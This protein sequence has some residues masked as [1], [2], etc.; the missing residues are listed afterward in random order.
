AAGV[1]LVAHCQRVVATGRR[2][3]AAGRGIGPRRQRLDHRA[4]L[5][6]PEHAIAAVLHS[7][8]V[9]GDVVHRI[10]Q[11]GDVALDIDDVAPDVGDIALDGGDP[12]FQVGN[13]SAVV[14]IDAVEACSQLA[15][16]D[17]IGAGDARRNAGDGAPAH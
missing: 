12:V 7:G 5:T 13:G 16:V 14:G 8:D 17:R 6:D 1:A 2:T 4:L 11:V 10:G 9:A 15:Y 3:V